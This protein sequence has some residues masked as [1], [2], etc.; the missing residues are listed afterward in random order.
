MFQI[1][2][3]APV[4]SLLETKMKLQMQEKKEEKKNVVTYVESA[5]HGVRSTVHHGET[6]VQQHI[7]RL[8]N[9]IMNLK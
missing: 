5:F 9:D 4:S 3:I 8:H 6:L 1:K 7:T 2:R